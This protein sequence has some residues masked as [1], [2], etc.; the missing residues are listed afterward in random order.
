MVK[1]MTGYGKASADAGTGKIS[2]EIR[3]LNGKGADIN[4]KSFILP[5]DRELALRQRVAKALERGSIDV[6]LTFEASTDDSARHID[7]T[8]AAEY[9]RQA[10][11]ILGY[12]NETSDAVLLA[13][14]LRFPEVCDAKKPDIITDENWP[15]VEAAVDNAL[16]QVD[17][18]R[19]REGAALYADVTSRISN[20][21][22][23]SARIEELERERIDAVKERLIRSLAELRQKVDEE[24]FHQ[25][26]IYYLEKLDINEE[27]V[28]LRQ[29]CS[30]FMDTIDNEPA[31][32]RKLG[33]I[34]QEMGR[35]INTTGSKANHG[36]IQKLVVLMKDELEKMREQC[37]N[38]L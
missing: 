24:R 21:L 31:P 15:A 29:H 22:G 37:M 9:L 33:F 19:R 3:T 10:K 14:I 17:E 20:I 23:L 26:M 8:A 5:K 30:Y 25:E 1:S 18:F 38:I 27:K 28:R 35:E 34:I 11:G 32:G 12:G 13:T 16:A 6:Y 4:I 2:V 36:G 7:K